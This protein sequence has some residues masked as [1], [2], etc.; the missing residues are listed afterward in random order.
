SCFGCLYALEGPRSRATGFAGGLRA[1]PAPVRAAR[2]TGRHLVRRR[3]PDAGARARADGEAA[4]AS[5]RRAEPRPCSADRA[6][7]F[8]H[9]N[10][11][12]RAWRLD[13]A[14]R[15]ECPRSARDCRLW[16]RS[17]NRL[18]CPQ[19]PG[20]QPHPRP[21]CH[22]QL[23]R[24]QGELTAMVSATQLRAQWSQ[25]FAPADRTL[26]AMLTRQAERFAQRPLLT[27][28][29]TTWTY[30]ETYEAAERCA[31][32]LRAAG[33]QPGDRVAIICS[34]RIEFLEIVLGCAW[35][36][37]VAVPINV[38]SRGPQLQHILSNCAARL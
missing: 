35:L 1:L 11:I 10:G 22:R 29:G 9:R 25:L 6:R 21:A 24:R 33:I 2:P 18:Y 7:D 5:S 36:S 15:A 3:T 32:T 16:L 19:R 23:S 14:R 13:P 34:N 26:P 17:G 38:A 4:I 28:G 27:A 37:A 8:P 20:S 30:A 31:G 12:A